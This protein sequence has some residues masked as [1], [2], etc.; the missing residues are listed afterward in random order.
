MALAHAIE[1]Q[2]SAQVSLLHADAVQ[3]DAAQLGTGPAKAVG[4]FLAGEP[5][6]LTQAPQLCREPTAADGSA[7]LRH[8]PGL[9]SVSGGPRE[10]VTS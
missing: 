10:G 4:H 2:E 9:L 1:S 6:A 3:F 5:G 8:A 7:L